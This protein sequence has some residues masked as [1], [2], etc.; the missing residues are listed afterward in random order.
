MAARVLNL[1][2]QLRRKIGEPELLDPVGMAADFLYG[3][4]RERR[5]ELGIPIH[6]RPTNLRSAYAIQERLLSR[7]LAAFPGSRIVGYKIASLG[8]LRGIRPSLIEPFYGRLL[9]SSSL[10]SPGRLTSQGFF[11]HGIEAS[12]SFLIA[13]DVPPGSG[14]HSVDTIAEFVGGVLPSFEVMETRFADWT[15]VGVPQ[16]AADNAIHGAWVHGALCQDWERY[17]FDSH[18]VRILVTGR[19]VRNGSGRSVFGNPLVALAW[20]ANELEAQE[21]TLRAG[22]F[23]STGPAT[24]VYIARPG[25]RIEGDFGA[26]GSVELSVVP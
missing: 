1:E 4:R 20:L 8:G 17:A 24:D 11:T 9:S 12:F 5:I 25:E 15:K 19:V 13:K 21:K 14:P 10:A 6:F 2:E 18:P 3:L 23:V 7:L 22:Q 26:I 16:L